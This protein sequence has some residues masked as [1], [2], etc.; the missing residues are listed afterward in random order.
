VIDLPAFR[1]LL[2]D[3]RWYARTF[4]RIKVK[5]PGVTNLA[6]F[7]YN[8]AQDKVNAAWEEQEKAGKPVRLIVPKARQE[9]VT[10]F[11]A[12]RILHRCATRKHRNARV[13]AHRADATEEIFSTYQRMYDNLP[14]QVLLDDGN[15]VQVK[16]KTKYSNRKELVFSDL[17]S[18]I[19]VQTAGADRGVAN[20]KGGAKGAGGG[21][22]GM[23]HYLHLSEFAF[24]ASQ[25]ETY[26][27]QAQRVPDAPGT[28]IV[29]ESTGNGVGDEF[30]TMCYDA[31]AGRNDF[32]LVFL[33][34]LD[35][36]EYQSP[37]PP[38]GLGDLSPKEQR[39]R[40]KLSATDMQLQWRRET[41]RNKCAGDEAQFEQEYPATLEEAFLVSGRPYFNRDAV[42]RTRDKHQKP[43]LW[44]GR[45]E[46][47]RQ[48]GPHAVRFIEDAG[49]YLSVWAK[50]KPDGRY[51]IGGDTAEGKATADYSCGEVIDR[52]TM[53]Q[54]AEWHGH[55]DP[56]L[57]GEELEKLGYWYNKAWVG[58]EINK[59]GIKTARVLADNNYPRLYRR[60]VLDLE[61]PEETEKIGWY[62]GPQSRPLMLAD[63]EAQLR[64]DQLIIHSEGFIQEMLVFVRDDTGKPAAQEGCHDD[65]VMAYAIA[66]QMH[67]LCPLPR[68][69]SDEERRRRERERRLATQPRNRRTG[70]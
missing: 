16:P 24:Y 20:K 48:K 29:I 1:S 4:L 46:W 59:E 64:E 63:M 43:P 11:V 44:V 54:A 51:A 38:G 30:Y 40:D 13:I 26:V 8:P 41:I 34:W 52:D 61:E 7:I 37:V 56:D 47:D 27:A 15:K 57:F 36:P 32:A 66:L 2:H 17:D 69:I 42:I 10:T 19:Q 60:D 22:G 62:T 25:K 70:Y 12:G 58:P 28:A 33:S 50:P 3:H 31:L 9:G 68:I 23:T 14:A 55:M 49:G 6:R 18:Q 35:F 5:D 67:Q 53:E 65:R 21:R 45:L 39:L